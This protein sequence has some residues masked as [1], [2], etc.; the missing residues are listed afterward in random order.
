MPNKDLSAV[1]APDSAEYQEMRGA[2][3]VKFMEQRVTP[4]MAKL[5]GHESE[6]LSCNSCH[7]R[8]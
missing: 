7:P 4:S 2:K 5:L 6:A 8:E 1:P 3:V